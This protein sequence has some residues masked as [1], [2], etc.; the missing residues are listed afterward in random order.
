MQKIRDLTG[1]ITSGLAGW[2]SCERVIPPRD[3]CFV[4]FVTC[5]YSIRHPSIHPCNPASVRHVS[6]Q[7]SNIRNLISIIIHNEKEDM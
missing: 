4:R 2:P 3:C 5:T 6:H 1:G 7:V